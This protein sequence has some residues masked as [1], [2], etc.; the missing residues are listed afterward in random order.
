MMGYAWFIKY[1]RTGKKRYLLYT[2]LWDTFCWWTFAY[3][4]FL[5]G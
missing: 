4:F 2:F 1:M 3:I 5:R